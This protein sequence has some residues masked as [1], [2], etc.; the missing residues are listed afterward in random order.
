MKNTDL[1]EGFTTHKVCVDDYCVVAYRKIAAQSKSNGHTVFC[2]NGGPGLPCDYLRDSHAILT[3]SG[4]DVV[5]YDQLGT[6]RSDKPEDKSLW[7]IERYA[8]EV[9]AVRAALGLEKMH[10]LGHSWGGWLAI[11]YAVT[12]Q[13]HL[14][15]LILQGTAADI[16]LLKSEMDRLRGALGNETL[17]MMHRYEAEGDFKNPE[18]NA[19]ISLLNHRHVC[20]LAKIPDSYQRSRDG[21]NRSI[22]EHMQGPNEFHYIGNLSNWSRRAEL[23]QV[24]VPA[25]ITA[26]AYDEITPVCSRNIAESLGGSSDVRIFQ[27]SSHHPHFEEPEAF[28]T[29]LTEFLSRFVIEPLSDHAAEKVT[30]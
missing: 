6:G 14:H 20:R 15:S 5:S 24:T 4:F 12:F 18:Y 13:Q 2:L 1:V 17:T 26:G 11:E 3:E 7:T 21:L 28:F 19:A 9:E 27:N 23:S 22:Y 25:L 30:V 8:Q 29:V 16:P 10:L